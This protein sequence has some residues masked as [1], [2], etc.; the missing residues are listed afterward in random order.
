MPSPLASAVELSIPFPYTERTHTRTHKNARAH[1][2]ASTPNPTEPRTRS[3][4]FCRAETVC[5]WF[6]VNQNVR[7]SCHRMHVDVPPA[8]LTLSLP[9]LSSSKA[10]FVGTHRGTRLRPSESRPKHLLTPGSAGETSGS[11]DSTNEGSM[12]R[13]PQSH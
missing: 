4:T 11:Q 3:S 10:H 13:H 8:K 6:A 9:T 5:R 1:A 2:H 12:A 7:P